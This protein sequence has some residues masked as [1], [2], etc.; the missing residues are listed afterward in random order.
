MGYDSRYLKGFVNATPADLLRG[1]LLLLA[2]G[3]LSGAALGAIYGLFFL[4]MPIK[5][6]VCVSL[7]VL[8]TPFLFMEA[9]DRGE[10][11]VRLSVG[12]F[13]VLPA[14]LAGLLFEY[15][16]WVAWAW[17]ITSRLTSDPILLLSPRDLVDLAVLVSRSCVLDYGVFTVPG[18]WLPALWATE[19]VVIV[20]GSLV[21]GWVSATAVVCNACGE[22]ILPDDLAPIRVPHDTTAF[23]GWLENSPPHALARLEPASPEESPFLRAVVWSCECGRFACL[24]AFRQDRPRGSVPPPRPVPMIEYLCVD[25]DALGA[26]ERLSARI[27][28]V[29]ASRSVAG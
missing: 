26:L 20:G 21:L 3:S 16:A 25:D 2:C 22:R 18:D 28:E 11:R 4:W 23:R 27:D 17:S 13:R 6:T 19:A 7:L 8:G 29:Y 1:L 9:L 5:A 14:V 12:R 10:Q 24:S 15:S